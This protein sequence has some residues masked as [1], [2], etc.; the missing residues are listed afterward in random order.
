MESGLAR[1]DESSD[2]IAIEK[3]T[4]ESEVIAEEE[5]FLIC[6]G[7]K[8]GTEIPL[9]TYPYYISFGFQTK[10]FFVS[11]KNNRRNG[12]LEVEEIYDVSTSPKTFIMDEYDVEEQYMNTRLNISEANFFLRFL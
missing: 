8:D 9:N 6:Q 1:S 12:K 2:A 11:K 4:S 10:M 7:M 5:V 3:L